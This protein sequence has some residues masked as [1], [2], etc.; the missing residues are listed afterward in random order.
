MIPCIQAKAKAR[1]KNAGLGRDVFVFAGDHSEECEAFLK[2]GTPSYPKL[3]M[4]NGKPL[5]FVAPF[6]LISD[7][8]FLCYTEFSQLSFQA[9]EK[10]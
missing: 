9:E 1:T 8:F 5:C 7:S 4:I 3:L 10:I 6:F 2:W